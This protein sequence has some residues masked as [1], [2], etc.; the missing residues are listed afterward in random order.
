[1]QLPSSSSLRFALA[2]HE[3]P[4][5]ESHFDLFLEQNGSLLSWRLPTELS[6]RMITFCTRSFDHRLEYLDYI[7]PV[8]LNRG[9]IRWQLSG[10]IEWVTCTD[11]EVT[12]FLHHPSLGVLRVKL[13][14]T[15]SN[16]LWQLTVSQVDQI[17]R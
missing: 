2:F 6:V 8:S 16:D 15:E 14:K 13:M 9:N 17:A 1:M 12:A 10:K 7:G 5:K 3:L 4:A 11:Q